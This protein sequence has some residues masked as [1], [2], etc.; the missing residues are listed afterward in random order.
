MN[1]MTVRK[2]LLL[3]LILI[4]MIVTAYCTYI[5]P[6]SSNIKTKTGVTTNISVPTE[7]SIHTFTPLSPLLSTW[8][9]IPSSTLTSEVAATKPYNF[10]V[11][12]HVYSDFLGYFF[13]SGPTSRFQQIDLPID[14]ENGTSIKAVYLEF[15]HF[16]NQLVYWTFDEPGQLWISDLA[17]SDKQVIFTD[18][19]Q[20]YL[21]DPFNADVYPYEDIRLRWSPDDMNVILESRDHPNLNLIYHVQSEA[22]EKFPFICDRISASPRSG[23]LATWCIHDNGN[24]YAVIE[25]GGDVW[26]STQP[27]AKVLVSR[28]K[29]GYETWAFSEDGQHVAY[30]NPNDP[31][32]HLIIANS[33]GEILINTISVSAFWLAADPPTVEMRFVEPPSPPI[34][35]SQDGSR[36]VVWGIGNQKNQ[37]PSMYFSNGFVAERVP[38]W[39]V[40]DT[41]NGTVVWSIFDNLDDLVGIGDSKHVTPHSFP[42]LALSPNS[43][44]L[45]ITGFVDFRVFCYIEIDRAQITYCNN[46]YVDN[47]RWGPAP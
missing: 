25:W 19:H 26:Y 45:S 17:I 30:F 8:T 3:F 29:E 13:F 31:K 38:C 41:L 37:C 27:P 4:L 36:L 7:P 28:I 21:A 14:T 32:A 15:A 33:R 6:L 24:E 5:E 22:L 23:L 11:Y 46:G 47:M 9:P 39:Q 2:L 35:W 1:L 18:E 16:S 43:K 44:Y 20:E 34:Q 12:A 40:I 42:R 10:G